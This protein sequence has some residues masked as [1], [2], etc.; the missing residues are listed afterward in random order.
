MT[1]LPPPAPVEHASPFD[2]ATTL[3]RLT[4]AIEAAGLTIFARIDHAE[5]A[6][7]AGLEM[8]PAVVLIY[9]HAKGGTPIMLSAP[10]VALDLPLRVLVRE[11]QAGTVVSWHSMAPVLLA[12]GAPPALA[13]RLDGAQNLLL[14]ALQP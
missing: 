5:G 9:G 12:A 11:S 4:A 13:N 10:R 2:V 6:R 8:P 14:K 1:E 3:Q 7:Q